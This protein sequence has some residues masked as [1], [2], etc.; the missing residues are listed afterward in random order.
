MTDITPEA[1]LCT[2]RISSDAS[3]ELRAL[4]EQLDAEVAG[5]G[6]VCE[7]SGRCCRFQEYGHTLFVSFIEIQFLLSH[8]PQPARPLDRGQTCP[9]QDGRNRCVARE[10]RPMGCRVYFCDPNYH[11]GQEISE[12]NITR[13]KQLTEKCGLPWNYAPLHHHLHEEREHG[14]FPIEMA[15]DSA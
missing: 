11:S 14:S 4:Y 9:W 6:P 12:R 13:L 1:E 15:N 8:A 2:P 7:L 10:A 3:L 5:L